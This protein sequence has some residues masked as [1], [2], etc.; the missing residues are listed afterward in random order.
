M[1]SSS[2]QKPLNVMAH[3]APWSKSKGLTMPLTCETETRLREIARKAG[4]LMVAAYL[5][6]NRSRAI[7]FNEKC[8]RALWALW[9]DEGG[10]S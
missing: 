5:S 2:A 3:A 8:K 7:H 1:R 6:G 4:D 9:I 10:A